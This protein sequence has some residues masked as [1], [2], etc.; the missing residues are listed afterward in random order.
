MQLVHAWGRLWN[1][2]FNEEKCVHV[3]FFSNF[4][5]TT[6]FQYSI[7]GST[8]TNCDHHKDLGAIMSKDLSWSKRCNYNVSKAYKILGMIRRA[9]KTSSIP[10]KHKAISVSRSFTFVLLLPSL[11]TCKRYCISWESSETSYQMHFEWLYLWLQV[12]SSLFSPTPINVLL[13]VMWF[14]VLH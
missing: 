12:S 4:E 8:I 6:S 7:N 3:Q 2:L 9:F 11:E 5:S 13:W 10:A 14:D 1:M